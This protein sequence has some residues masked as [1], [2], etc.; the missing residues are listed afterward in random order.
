MTSSAPGQYPGATPAPAPEAQHQPARHEDRIRRNVA[1][2]NCRNSKVPACFATAAGA[3]GF[4]DRP[5][6]RSG[7]ERALWLAIPASAVLSWKYP[8]L[9]ISLIRGSRDGGLFDPDSRSLNQAAPARWPVQSIICNAG[10]SR[11]VCVC[12]DLALAFSSKLEQLEQELKSIK[13]AVNTKAG[14]EGSIP[15]PSPVVNLYVSPTEPR[16][17]SIVVT[18]QETD[19]SPE[20]EATSVRVSDRPLKATPTK[21]RTIGAKVVDGVEIDHYFDRY[22]WRLGD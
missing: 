5:R 19:T 2:V 22:V 7:V 4:A 13:Q 16:G 3:S 9:L 21:P 17:E 20:K 6:C 15:P 1:C 8:V 18:S 12:A 11:D 14:G 10:V